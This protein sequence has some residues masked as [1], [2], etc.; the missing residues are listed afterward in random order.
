MGHVDS[1]V[2][3]DSPTAARTR[4]S[5]TADRAAPWVLAFVVALA[6]VVN[7]VDWTRPEVIV[8]AAASGAASL[9][10]RRSGWPL[11]AVAAFAWLWV[12]MWPVV[13]VASY[14]SGIGER[15]GSR[16]VAY[17]VLTAAAVGL[18]ALF[19]AVEDSPRQ[20]P[21]VGNALLFVTTLVL[22]P[23]AVGMWV[24]ARREVIE[25]LHR[26]A[27]HLERE[28]HALNGRER[29][30]ER[31]RIAREMHDVVAHRVSLMVL[32]AGA[33]EVNAPDQHTALAAASIRGLG[34]EALMDLRDVLG[35]LRQA[36]SDTELAPPS[37]LADLDR[38]LEHSR[39]AGVPVA[40][41]DEGHPLPL[42][43]AV[44]T[45]AYRVVQEALTNVH[46][47]AGDSPTHVRLGHHHDQLVV[48]VTNAAPTEQTTPPRAGEYLP[49]SGL[50]LVG[51]HERVSLLQGDLEAGP[52]PGGG[53]TVLAR[54]PI[55][56]PVSDR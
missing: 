15:R 56:R 43:A 18:P 27:E 55:I 54:I 10:A 9:V 17:T 6:S 44:D 30:V 39:G 53:F 49:G 19:V 52:C 41:H 46:R 33:L 25:G 1:G 11:R 12:G 16:L 21:S 51:L 37:G 38:L 35:V 5:G 23:V 13:A 24:A 40:R 29:A 32:Q 36:D 8:L 22:L 47:H 26:R 45:A 14:Y 42:P 7:Y 4:L 28:R 20:V 2:P 48:E 50:G 31:A 3:A 34:R